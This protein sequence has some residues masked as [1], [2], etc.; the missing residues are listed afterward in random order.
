MGSKKLIYNI[1]QSE[2]SSIIIVM[3]IQ[4]TENHFLV[5]LTFKIISRSYTLVG[6][7]IDIN[8][9]GFNTWCI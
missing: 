9:Y 4:Q 6:I 7:H 2:S 1:L 3:K 8:P 5:N